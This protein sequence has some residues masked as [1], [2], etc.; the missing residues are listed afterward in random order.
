ML[1]VMRLNGD[2]SWLIQLDNT[3]LI[4]DPWLVGEQVDVARWFNR[5]SH[6]DKCL[7]VKDLPQ[8]DAILISHPFTDHCHEATLK[9]FSAETPIFASP[10]AFKIIQKWHYFEHL[11]VL[12]SSAKTPKPLII[13][14][15]EVYFLA[16]NH[17]LD[18]TH[19]ALFLRAKTSQKT[20]F[21]APHGY[22]ANDLKKTQLLDNQAI[23]LVLC[24]FSLY[25]LPWYLGGTVNFGANNTLQLLQKLQAKAALATHDERKIAQG[26]VAQLAQTAYTNNLAKLL[27]DKQLG[28][29]TPSLEIGQLIEL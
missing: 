3:R 5:Q 22:W 23:D 15:I 7:T 20:V 21:Y 10:R 24:T 17:L 28:T 12:N 14:D 6:Q 18:L 16:A 9:Q 13:K 8:V 26:L 19:Q 4:L 29:Q 11:H 1:K 27:I 2:S 25:K